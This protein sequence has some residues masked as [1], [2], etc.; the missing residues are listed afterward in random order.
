MHTGDLPFGKI[1]TLLQDRA[2]FVLLET[3]KRDRDNTQSFLFLDPKKI[4]HAADL[5]EAT[6]ILETHTNKQFVAGAIRYDGSADLGI[7]DQRIMFDHRSGT[8]DDTLIDVD[9]LAS[10]S[11]T[12]S[13]VNGLRL[14]SSESEY[15]QFF[16]RVME[17]LTAG[18]SYQVNLTIPYCFD[19]HGCIFSLY[20]RLRRSQRVSYAALIRFSDQWIMSLSPELFFR[21]N[22]TSMIV[23]PMKGTSKPGRTN[24]EDQTR[25]TRLQASVKER[26]ENTMI[27]DLLRSDL[28]KISAIGSVEVEELCAVEKFET[29]LQMTSTIRSRLKEGVGWKEIFTA[30]FPSGSVTGAPKIRT[31]EIIREIEKGDRGVSYGSIGFAGPEGHGVFS[32]AIRTMEL[33]T[34][35]VSPPPVAPQ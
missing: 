28:G 22:G 19:Y 14:G 29:V 35:L 11:F 10:F 8:F 1:A 6:A 30:L 4:I 15:K 17:K 3:L 31:M 2:D 27:V 5:D 25:A 23:K 33:S 12:E 34:L 18:E 9:S 7:F 21:R 20:E 24:A 16:T 13:P 26:A 32:V